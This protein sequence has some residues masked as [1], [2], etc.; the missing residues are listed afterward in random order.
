MHASAC[1]WSASSRPGAGARVRRRMPSRC[2]VLDRPASTRT[3][4]VEAAHGD[5]RQL[6]VERHE[7]FED[8]RHAA[9][10][11]PRRVDVAGRAQ[12]GL[13]LAVVAAPPRLQHR[14]QAE[15]VDR[16]VAASAR[17]STARNGAVAIPSALQRCPS[18]RAGPA[19]P[20][21]RA[22]GGRTGASAASARAVAAGHA[23]PLVGD[24]VGAVGGLR[25]GGRR[26]R[27]P[28][29]TRSPTARGRRLGR[30]IEERERQPSG[31]PAE[32]EHPARAGRRPAPPPASWRGT[33]AIGG[34]AHASSAQRRDL[35]VERAPAPRGAATR[36]CRADA[37][38][39]GAGC[40]ISAAYSL[41][42]RLE[43][44]LHLLELR[45]V[46]LP[47]QRELARAA[48]GSRSTC[49][50]AGSCRPPG[51]RPRAPRRA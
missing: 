8:Q 11:R 43:P 37:A 18:R 19:T 16:R 21:A 25:R 26:R 27:A 50:R 44:L 38:A 29:T 17:S 48:R 28:P 13:A 40:V 1:A 23:F 22:A 45:R 41:R 47:L 35:G 9:E 46:L 36:S 51:A 3:V 49:A 24:D 39:R 7:P 12:H 33:L 34:R 15:R 14:G 32:P 31:M 2:V 30:R 4:A 20:R 10:R 5:D 42:D 6:A